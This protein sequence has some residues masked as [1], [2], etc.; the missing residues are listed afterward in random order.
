MQV[1]ELFALTMPMLTIFEIVPFAVCRGGIYE[2]KMEMQQRST[3]GY[4]ILRN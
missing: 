2:M 4:S 3:N 1:A